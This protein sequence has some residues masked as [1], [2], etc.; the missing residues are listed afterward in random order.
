MKGKRYATEEKI[1]IL[2]EADDSQPQDWFCALI[3]TR[4]RELACPRTLIH[5]L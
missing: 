5:L 4:V 3:A 2:R 1:R